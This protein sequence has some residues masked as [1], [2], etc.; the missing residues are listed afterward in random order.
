[1][2]D[3][4]DIKDAIVNNLADG[5]AEKQIGDRRYRYVS[6]KEAYEVMKE[7]AADEMVKDGPFLKAKFKP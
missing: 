2:S 5:I 6:P 3:S 7:I 4:E 1:M